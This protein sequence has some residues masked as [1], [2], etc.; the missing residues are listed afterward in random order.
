VSIVT[1]FPTT[2]FTLTL[3]REA[4]RLRLGGKDLGEVKTLRDFRRDSF[5]V[6][7]GCTHLAFD[8]AEGKTALHA[9]LA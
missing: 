2:N 5:L 1:K 8:L 3:N 9:A 6:K 4:K 7:D